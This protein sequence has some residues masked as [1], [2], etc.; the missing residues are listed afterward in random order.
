MPPSEATKRYPLRAIGAMAL[1]GTSFA[2]DVVLLV[3]T[4]T[5]AQLVTQS[6][7]VKDDSTAPVAF[8]EVATLQVWPFHVSA[9]VVWVEPPLSVQ[10]P[11][12]AVHDVALKQD[13][14]MRNCP[15][16]GGV[17]GKRGSSV[18][19]DPFQFRIAFSKSGGP[20][21]VAYPTAVQKP[22]SPTQ[23]TEDI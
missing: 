5:Q 18:Q 7:P 4:A 6:T 11:P 16:A 21:I 22:A 9:S 3:P 17:L 23:D 12:T 1:K 19:V 8:G 15:K 14:P 20:V 13:T 2:L 10:V